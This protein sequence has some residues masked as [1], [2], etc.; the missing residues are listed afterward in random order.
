MQALMLSAP[1]SHTHLAHPARLARAALI[2]VMLGASVAPLDF[3]L[4][5]GFPAIA[6]DF[7]LGVRQ[8]R[9]AAISYVLTYGVLMLWL[10]ALGD[11]I[12]HLRV[13]AVGLVLSTG[14][15]VVCALAPS[16]GLLLMGR[17][18]MGLGVA[19]TLSC[20]PA[21]ALSLYDDRQRTR[22]LSAYG[23]LF[24]LAGLLS[25]LAG[26]WAMDRL[27]WPGVFWFR[28]PVMALA[29]LGLPVLVRGRAAAD[30]AGVAASAAAAVARVEGVAPLASAPSAGADAQGQ[31][32]EPMPWW[33]ARLWQAP[34]FARINAASVV[35]QFAGFSVLL[36]MPFYLVRQGGW[37]PGAIGLTL[38]CWAS[39]T[40]LGSAVAARWIRRHGLASAAL[41]GTVLAALGLGIAALWPPQPQL[42]PLVLAM[43]VQGMGVGV[44]Q[45]AY[46]DQVVA[47]LPSHMRGVA[48]SLTMVTRTAGVVLGALVWPEV[49]ETAGATV[50]MI[51]HRAVF[52]VAALTATGLALVLWRRR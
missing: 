21:L 34:G 25:P 1:P 42:L 12:G 17:V 30:A 18:L 32:V 9:W 40:M 43:A 14:S 22:V 5:I 52:A 50:F 38:A 10:G 44:F 8:I 26:G 19:F 16:Y 47:A 11:R 15:L 51:G 36:V 41:W 33:S 45:V 24:A 3:A 28:L 27:G 49:L 2:V 37:S 48:G 13:F 4:A 20:A 46:A 31:P 7:G 39:G 35:L 23:S 6:E 29:L